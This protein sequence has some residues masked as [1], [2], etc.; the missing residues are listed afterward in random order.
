MQ[1]IVT[2]GSGLVMQSHTVCKAEAPSPISSRPASGKQGRLYTQA[3]QY[4][5]ARLKSMPLLEVGIGHSR[6]CCL[7]TLDAPAYLHDHDPRQ[8]AAGMH[9]RHAQRAGR[10]RRRRAR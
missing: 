5:P 2:Q 9:W 4:K 3:N 10:C 6:N 8:G 1:L 7:I